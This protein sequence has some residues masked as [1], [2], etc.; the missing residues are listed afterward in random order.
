MVNSPRPTN[1]SHLAAATVLGQ[2]LYIAE[3]R[4]DYD[5]AILHVTDFQAM[6]QLEELGTPVW[7]T[8]EL[9]GVSVKEDKFSLST[10]A[11]YPNTCS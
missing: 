9:E 8:V 6:L 10:T 3:A 2:H 1:G 4:A 7:A 11:G 5:A